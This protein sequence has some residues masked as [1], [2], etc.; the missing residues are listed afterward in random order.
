MVGQTTRTVLVCG[1][2]TYRHAELLF[3]VLDERGASMSGEQTTEL[4]LETYTDEPLNGWLEWGRRRIRKKP[5]DMVPHM[6]VALI[7]EVRRLRQLL[8]EARGETDT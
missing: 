4:R 6:I 2:R 1:G 3:R 5:T 7:F 8:R